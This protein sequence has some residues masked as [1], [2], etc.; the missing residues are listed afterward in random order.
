MTAK[1]EY[2]EATGTAPAYV[3]WTV[4]GMAP[5]E[6]AELRFWAQMPKTA[7]D[8]LTE[9]IVEIERIFVN[10]ATAIDVYMRD[11]TYGVDNGEHGADDKIWPDE[12]DWTVE[13]EETYH[14]ITEPIPIAYKTSDKQKPGAFGDD[15]SG[16]TIVP[17]KGKDSQIEYTITLENNSTG[18]TLLGARIRDYIP[19]GTRLVS[20]GEITKPER[21]VVELNDESDAAKPRLT[22]TIDKLSPG[23]AVKVRFTV[24][25]LDNPNGAV[26]IENKAY[27]D[28]T[29]PTGDLDE[30]PPEETN[31]LENPVLWHTKLSSP[32]GVLREG[33]RV[34][35]LIHVEVPDVN[36]DWPLVTV[37]DT[38]PNGTTYVRN[39]IHIDDVLQSDSKY[40]NGSISFI[41]NE[42]LAPGRHVFRFS[43]VVGKLPEGVNQMEIRNAA[44]INGD[45]TTEVKQDVK[46]RYADI[47]KKSRLI[48]FDG[49]E[50]EYNNGGPSFAERVT[51]EFGQE[52]E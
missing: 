6:Q 36:G 15:P 52:I 14:R 20:V 50:L 28:R 2:V 45:P 10:K 51:A 35:Y 11:K 38:V 1:T 49:T 30:D 41:A 23:E 7:D 34:T 24:E 32:T 27:Y 46:S 12:E 44:L 40:S 39:S 48:D 4:T 9:D 37:A 25:V 26:L 3:K 47:T 8:P 33:Q 29:N 13:S 31:T 19:E 5:G 43:V 17:N 18:S 22:W 21:T 42:P 16:L